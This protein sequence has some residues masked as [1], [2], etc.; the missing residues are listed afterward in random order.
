MMRNLYVWCEYYMAN[1]IALCYLVQDGA[2]E[3]ITLRRAI[4]LMLCCMIAHVVFAIDNILR[5]PGCIIAIPLNSIIFWVRR[6]NNFR[7]RER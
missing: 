5:I 6:F 1:Y 7:K 2:W 3:Y 4:K